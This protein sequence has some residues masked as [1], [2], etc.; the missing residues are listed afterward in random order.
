MS[1]QLLLDCTFRDGGYKNNWNF[2][3]SL[4]S[5]SCLRLDECGVNYIEIGY[6]NIKAKIDKKKLNKHAQIVKKN[7]NYLKRNS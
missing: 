1:T 5:E 4:V 6:K 2:D 3:N 7:I